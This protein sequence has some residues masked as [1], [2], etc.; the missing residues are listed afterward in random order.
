LTFT[1]NLLGGATQEDPSA[2]FAFDTFNL[3]IP[4]GSYLTSF[5]LTN[6]DPARYDAAIWLDNIRFSPVPDAGSTGTL[7]GIVLGIL[8]LLKCKS[9][10]P[11]KTAS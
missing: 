10:L 11:S 4:N 6:R 5:E 7:L 9:L 1:S 8:C 3:N 2:P